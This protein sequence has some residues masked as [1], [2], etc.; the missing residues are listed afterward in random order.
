MKHLVIGAS[1]QVGGALMQVLYQA[2][3]EAIGTYLTHPIKGLVPL[4]MTRAADMNAL[5][6]R[7]QPDVVWIPGAAPDVDRCEREPAFSYQVNV[8]G[9]L[10]AM[11]RVRRRGIPLVYFS[12]DYVFDG[13]AGPYRER[14]PVS[15]LQVYGQHKVEA[16]I[17]LLTYRDTLVVRP[18]WI[19]SEEPNPRNFAYR[20]LSDLKAGKVIK[21][22]LDQ[23]S[24][25]TPAIPLARQALKALQEGQ[26]GILHLAGPERMTRLELVQ[27]LA[28]RGGFSDTPIEAIRVG[29]LP[30]PAQRP[31]QGGLISDFPAYAIRETLED[32][33]F[34][35]LLTA[36]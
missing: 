33:D 28:R 26:R 27:R 20:V 16:E 18:A 30:L 22:A 32:T 4:D 11:E 19:Y 36:P 14:D 5:M 2:G 6:D 10:N 13:L 35:Q 29:D 12:T 8:V 15:P 31:L 25:P 1:G 23:V 21:S 24:T 34:R 9:P 17:G 7:E 3:H